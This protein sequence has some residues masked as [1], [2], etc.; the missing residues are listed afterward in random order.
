MWQCQ[1]AGFIIEGITG[2][3]SARSLRT[4]AL[5]H[6]VCDDAMEDQIV[7][8]TLLREFDEVSCG[9]GGLFG[10]E[11]DLD[12]ALAGRNSR[13]G[14]LVLRAVAG[15]IGCLAAIRGARSVTLRWRCE[16]QK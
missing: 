14:H 15:N 2:A 4:S 6:E 5:D 8:E 3:A 12:G 7:I 16:G 9:L 11:L 10:K 1:C 13:G